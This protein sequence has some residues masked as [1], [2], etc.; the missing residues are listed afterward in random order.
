MSTTHSASR[1]TS[2][3]ATRSVPRSSVRPVARPM[4]HPSQPAHA[5]AFAPTRSPL[6][7]ALRGEWSQLRFDAAGF[8]IL[9]VTA[10]IAVTWSAVLSNLLIR[11][12]GEDAAPSARAAISGVFQF[13]MYGLFIWIARY[14]LREERTG[15]AKLKLLSLPNRFAIWVAK[16]VWLTIAAVTSMLFMAVLSTAVTLGSLALTGQPWQQFVGVNVTEYL[17]MGVMITIIA[18]GTVAFGVAVAIFTNNLSFALSML[19]MWV[20]V[21]EGMMNGADESTR[22][23]YSLL[24]FKNG[25]RVFENAP[26]EWFVWNPTVSVGYFLVV[27]IGLAALAITLNKSKMTRGE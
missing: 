17:K 22:I 21:I 18:V 27:T 13:A 23:L 7:R 14:L 24:P 4:P 10:M 2:R 15:F 12:G 5:S 19:F 8:S 11:Y 6:L 1:T 25:T 16:W 9:L 26:M 20:L 3:T